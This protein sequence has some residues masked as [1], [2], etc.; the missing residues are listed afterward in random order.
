MPAE[1]G[2]SKFVFG[3]LPLSVVYYHFK[4]ARWCAKII[5]SRSHAGASLR[6]TTQILPSHGLTKTL[7]TILTEPALLNKQESPKT[8]VED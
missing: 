8:H 6:N 3:A 1:W 5:Y 7:H 2:V 4:A